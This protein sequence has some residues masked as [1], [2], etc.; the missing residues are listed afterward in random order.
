MSNVH[1]RFR[2]PSSLDHQSDLFEIERRIDVITTK[3]NKY[4][5]KTIKATV[6]CNG[7]ISE[8]IKAETHLREASRITVSGY[9]SAKSKYKHQQSALCSMEGVL[10][11][12]EDIRFTGHYFGKSDETIAQMYGKSKKYIDDTASMVINEIDKIK[13][14]YAVTK[15]QFE[16][17]EKKQMSKPHIQG[18]HGF[19]IFYKRLI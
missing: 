2:N 18:Y 1:T 19:L 8:I 9:D 17:W 11:L 13:E 7:L 6:I 12:L 5:G 4:V 14:Q 3:Q 10:K 15:R 16:A